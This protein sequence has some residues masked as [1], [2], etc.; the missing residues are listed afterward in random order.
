MTTT[1]TTLTTSLGAMS[2]T[3]VI[4]LRSIWIWTQIPTWTWTTARGKEC[5]TPSLLPPLRLDLLIPLVMPQTQI[6]H[7]ICI[8]C[9]LVRRAHIPTQLWLATRVSLPQR[10]RPHLSNPFHHHLPPPLHLISTRPVPHAFLSRHPH[11]NLSPVLPHLLPLVSRP[12]ISSSSTRTETQSSSC[13]DGTSPFFGFF[14][15][16]LFYLFFQLSL[17]ASFPGAR[18]HRSPVPS[19]PSPFH[20][21]GRRSLNAAMT[22]LPQRWYVL[23]FIFWFGLFHLFSSLSS[24]RFISRAWAYQSPVPSNLSRWVMSGPVFHD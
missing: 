2:E 17:D 6:V 20:A 23:F 8:Q 22:H 18:A 15:F 19:N 16:G 7:L 14:G 9:N 10:V 13:A 5:L 12:G 1:V 11:L 4:P 3:W 21:N 24:R